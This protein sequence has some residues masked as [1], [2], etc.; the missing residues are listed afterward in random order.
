MINF[1]NPC[2]TGVFIDKS[3]SAAKRLSIV[4]LFSKGFDWPKVIYFDFY[5]QW[6]NDKLHKAHFFQ[7]RTFSG[8]IQSFLQKAECLPEYL[9]AYQTGAGRQGY[10]ET[11]NCLKTNFP[12]Y[13]QELEG[14]ADGANVPFHKVSV[15]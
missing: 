4:Y 9:E 8:I 10:D 13:V 3:D 15:I 12:Q 14:T 5:I 6:I 2:L 1:I 7:G 11:L